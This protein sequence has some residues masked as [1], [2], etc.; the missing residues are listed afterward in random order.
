MCNEIMSSKYHITNIEASDNYL[1]SYTSSESIVDFNRRYLNSPQ[2]IREL[3]KEKY[4]FSKDFTL[5]DNNL[6]TLFKLKDFE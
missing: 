2:D 5:E 1:I 6:I 4:E 3:Y